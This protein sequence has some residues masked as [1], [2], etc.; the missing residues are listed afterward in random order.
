MKKNAEHMLKVQID[1]Q[2]FERV[3][4]FKSHPVKPDA[5]HPRLA[6][7]VISQFGEESTKVMRV[8]V[9]Q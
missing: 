7:R 2:A 6:V 9:S 1:D 3:Y 4:G 8:G 5:E